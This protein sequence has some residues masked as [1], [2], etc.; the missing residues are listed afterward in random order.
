[1]MFLRSQRRLMQRLFDAC[2]DNDIEATALT[3]AQGADPIWRDKKN[4]V[5]HMQAVTRRKL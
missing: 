1:M 4:S 3:L 5:R 2:A